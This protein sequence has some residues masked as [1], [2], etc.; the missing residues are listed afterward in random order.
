[1]KVLFGVFLPMG[2]RTAS[3]NYVA[4]K[5]EHGFHLS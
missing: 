1:M 3:L 5:I 4:I 2:F